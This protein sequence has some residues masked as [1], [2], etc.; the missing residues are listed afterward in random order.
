MAIHA[1]TPGLEAALRA[2]LGLSKPLTAHPG[3]GGGCINATYVLH[4]EGERE[5]AAFLK[6][7]Q[8]ER[9]GMF[10]TEAE[11]LSELA[12][13]PETGLRLPRALGCGVAGNQAWLLLEYLPLVPGG[14]GAGAYAALGAGLARLHR[15]RSTNGCHGW[16]RDNA[17]G[18]TPQRNPW[19]RDWAAFFRDHRLA[20]QFE[21]AAAHGRAFRQA[22]TLLERVPELLRDHQPAPSLLHGDL[23]S[24]NAAFLADGTPVIFDPA[25]YYGDRE[26]DLAFTRMFGGFPA[27]FD[28]AYEREWPLPAGHRR[29]AELYNLYHLLN[30]LNLFGE[31]YGRQA[32][33]VIAAL[34]RE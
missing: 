30:H 26:T 6:L 31:P 8:A 3:R 7:N 25:S 4:G 19:T 23:W 15:V 28:Q 11:A 33:Q 21:L 9:A 13:A 32:E 18:A 1:L 34:L 12:A 14:C 17:I 10:E 20:F 27:A 5:P 24:G 22:E 2:A 16:R 29:R